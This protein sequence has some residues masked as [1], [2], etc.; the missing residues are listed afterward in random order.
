M[1]TEKEKRI[2]LCG[3]I[4]FVIAVILLTCMVFGNENVELVA[5]YFVWV[6]HFVIV[7]TLII[8]GI[9]GDL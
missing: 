1:R 8:L 7:S 9:K 4:W 6:D 3:A 2:I 5:S